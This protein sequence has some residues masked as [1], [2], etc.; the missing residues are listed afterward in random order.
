MKSYL[1]EVKNG[2]LA[3]LSIYYHLP[4]TSKI[5]IIFQVRRESGWHVKQLCHGRL[6][7]PDQCVEGL[8]PTCLLGAGR[9]VPTLCCLLKTF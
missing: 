8:G 1:L 5:K 7:V 4:V 2:V 9:R 3:E 6:R